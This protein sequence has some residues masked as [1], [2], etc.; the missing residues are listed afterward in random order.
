MM[1]EMPATVPMI[2]EKEETAKEELGE[3]PSL[4]SK[5]KLT[6]VTTERLMK[7]W[8]SL[9]YAFFHPTPAIEIINGHHAHVFECMA[10][11]CKVCI[12]R[13]LNKK[14]ARSTG[15]MQKHAKS[16]WGDDVL[17]ACDEAKNVEEVRT[18]IVTS[19]LHN[20]SITA[21]FKHKGKGKVTYSHRQ[22]TRTETKWV[23]ELHLHTS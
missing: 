11:G 13:F 2:T 20:G 9:I 21:S 12:R 5:Y 8:N 4:S 10:K 23:L 18:K 15:N 14:D 1:I 7:E 19:V 16:C 3:G 6:L 17:Q 22:H